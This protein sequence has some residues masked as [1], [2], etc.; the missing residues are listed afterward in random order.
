[1][2]CAAQ[3]GRAADTSAGATAVIASREK[4]REKFAKDVKALA[5]DVVRH[6]TSTDAQQ[7]LGWLPV[8]DPLVFTPVLLD[9]ERREATASD[10]PAPA[11]GSWQARWLALRR[12]FAAE[13][14]KLVPAAL[15]AHQL[16]LA[17][18]L[19]LDAARNDHSLDAAWQTLGYVRHEGAWHTPFEVQKLKA[20]QV[21]SPKFG[22]LPADKLARYEKGERYYLARW[23]SVEE[24]A[25]RRTPS[26]E[27][28]W[29]AVSEHFNVRTNHSLEA[30][31]ELT[32][33]LERMYRAWQQLFVRYYLSEEQLRNRLTGR[34]V[35]PPAKRH[36]IE[37]FRNREQYI[38]KFASAQP[39]ISKTTGYYLAKTHKAY[40]FAPQE[41]DDEETRSE[42]AVNLF[43]EATHQLFHES[44]PV[45]P[46]VG[47]TANFWVIEGVACYFESFAPHADNGT[48]RW[49]LGGTDA[50]RLGN[51]RYRLAHDDFFIPT[52]EFCRIG[53]SD[54]QTDPRIGP[55]YSQSSG[56]TYYL[57][58]ANQ[59]ALREPL[60]AYLQ[61]IYVGKDD[62][63][64]LSQL[65]GIDYPALDE[66]YQTWLGVRKK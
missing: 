27:Q 58:H 56:L 10:E 37:Y 17:Y 38:A 42:I 14:F 33:R 16:T 2:T 22:W 23:M 59:G 47:R 52:A 31:V 62:A 3:A 64:T 13:S 36:Q 44:R 40:F 30:G 15:D 61:Q 20:G 25:R 60:V 50:V 34:S 65:L 26:V 8:D 24:E 18:A 19:L 45:A 53:M 11:E 29:D 46:D 48:V 63:G 21:W 4:L 51:A 43:H 54:F 1:L 66:R 41:T 57:M 5:K 55:M 7:L 6:G 39:F 32:T 49:T 28:G 12:E 9:D 35:E